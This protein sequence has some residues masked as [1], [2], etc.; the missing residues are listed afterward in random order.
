M[1]PKATSGVLKDNVKC[2]RSKASM[3]IVHIFL[4]R[5]SCDKPN[6]LTH[7]PG[8]NHLI[9]PY[10]QN[11]RYLSAKLSACDAVRGN[12]LNINCLLLMAQ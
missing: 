1:Q 11:M 4:I 2:R 10:I 7:T 5:L 9:L 6:N 12:K 3:L 8:E